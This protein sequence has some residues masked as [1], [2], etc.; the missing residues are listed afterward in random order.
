VKSGLFV[1]WIDPQGLGA[2]QCR[3]GV[4]ARGAP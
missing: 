3:H 4:L 1:Q 2:D